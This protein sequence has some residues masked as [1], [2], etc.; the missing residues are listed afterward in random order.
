MESFRSSLLFRAVLAACTAT[1]SIAVLG[2]E[3][4]A[5][6]EGNTG[7][8]VHVLWSQR[9]GY[10]W[11]SG[12][13]QNF[14]DIFEAYDSAK[15][16]DFKVPKAHTWVI[17]EVY[18][19]GR[20]LHG[21][22]PPRSE[23]VTFYKDTNGL[24]G[25]VVA[26]YEVVG[27]LGGGAGSFRMRI[28]KTALEPGVYWLSVVANMDYAVGGE[29]LWAISTARRLSPSAWENP[30]GAYRQGCPTW[31]RDDINHS[32]VMFELKGRE[33]PAP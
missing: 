19:V 2:A 22:G 26:T 16:D 21:S 28:P 17:E 5:Q 15:A 33:R 25:D 3:R 23:Q 13:S 24:P 31:C 32:N 11:G 10:P 30:G 7:D 12:V 14:E 18:V 6:D 20:Y 1:A 4:A 29:W 9:H 8:G 27:D